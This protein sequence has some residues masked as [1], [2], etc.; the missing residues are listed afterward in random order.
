MTQ[1]RR[2]SARAIAHRRRGDEWQLPDEV[3]LG[4]LDGATSWINSSPFTSRD[5]E[6]R[7]V[8]V[9]FWTYTC[10][11][12][13]RTLPYLRA[14]EEAYSTSGLAIVGV[15]TPEFSFERRRENVVQQVRRRVQP[16]PQSRRLEDRRHHRRRRPLPGAAADVHHRKPQMRIA[17]M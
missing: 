8:L 1:K 14:W 12:W 6:G 15:H 10:I 7:V 17:K 13:L 2:A 4:S 5:L 11:N 3:R 16:R 9:D